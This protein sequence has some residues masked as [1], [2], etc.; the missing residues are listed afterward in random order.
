M[1]TEF[2]GNIVLPDKILYGGKLS[3]KGDRIEKIEIGNYENTEKLPFICPGFVDI[4]HHGALGHDYMEADEE[5]FRIISGHLA[6]CGVTAGLCTT[7][8]ALEEDIQNVLE[9]FRIWQNNADEHAGCR[10]YGL[11]LEGPFLAEKSKGAHPLE[12]LKVPTDGYQYIL[13][14]KDIIRRIT[15]APELPGMEEMIPALKQA[16]IMV[17]GGHDNAEPEHIESAIELGMNQCTHIYCV[18]STLHKTDAHRKCGLC[19][20]GMTSP[21]S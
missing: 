7:I 14:N 4:H 12:V 15:L 20:Y 5:T 9:A 13:D 18:M 16:G 17:S 1:T 10:F 19:E 6:S 11:H 8:S 2:I 3:C 21:P